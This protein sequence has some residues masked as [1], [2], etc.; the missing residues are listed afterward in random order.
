MGTLR[1]LGKKDQLVKKSK[2]DLVKLIYSKQ[3]GISGNQYGSVTKKGKNWYGA[4]QYG[5]IK[6]DGTAWIGTK[7]GQT[8]KTASKAYESKPVRYKRAFKVD[9]YP[10][11]VHIFD[12]FYSE[13]LYINTKDIIKMSVAYK[14]TTGEVIDY[15]SKEYKIKI[16]AFANDIYATKPRMDIYYMFT[17]DLKK[18]P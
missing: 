18:L 17:N 14:P 10:H 1:K 16:K 3:K 13:D 5:D 7:K 6:N 8:R 12:T 9:I 4:N 11:K 2:A 15:M